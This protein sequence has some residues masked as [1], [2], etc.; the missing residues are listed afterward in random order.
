[1]R[2][3]IIVCDKNLDFDIGKN[4]FYI[5]V[6]NGILNLLNKNILIDY[7]CCDF[8]SINKKDKEYILKQKKDRI[9]KIDQYP[10]DKENLD[11]EVAINYAIKKDLKNIEIFLPNNNRY[12]FNL[13]SLFWFNKYNQINL[14]LYDANNLIFSLAKGKHI[15]D[16]TKY[17]DYKY[18]TFVSL[19]FAK[20]IIEDAKYNGEFK[21]FQPVSFFCSNEFNNKNIILNIKKGNVIVMLYKK[22]GI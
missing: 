17:K 7:A 5:G 8:D 14:R 1:M 15:L 19:K 10:C 21:I 22:N 16:Y 6:E 18:I 9:K 13:V 2:K 4:I 11:G 20:I 3:A 12:D